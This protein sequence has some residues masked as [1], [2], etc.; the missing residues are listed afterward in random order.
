MATQIVPMFRVAKGAIHR[1]EGALRVGPSVDLQ[2]GRIAVALFSRERP[3]GSI[4]RDTLSG[5][6]GPYVSPEAARLEARF[7]IPTTMLPMV[8]HVESNLGQSSLVRNS[9]SIWMKHV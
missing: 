4:P 9:A 2:S 6:W 1:R 7:E 5:D 8:V 3:R